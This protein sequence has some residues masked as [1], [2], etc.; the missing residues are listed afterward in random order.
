MSLEKM[1]IDKINAIICEDKMTIDQLATV[2]V[3]TDKMTLDETS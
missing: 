2:K 3:I 1:T